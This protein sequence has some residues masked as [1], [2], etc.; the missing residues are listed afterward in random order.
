MSALRALA[1]RGRFLGH[2]LRAAIRP[3]LP[4]TGNYFVA[5]ISGLELPRHP[6]IRRSRPRP[7]EH[8]DTDYARRFDDTSLFY[9]VFQLDG[10]VVAVGPP[11]RNLAEL[12]DSVS[13]SLDGQPVSRESDLL[14]N[15]ERSSFPGSGK[16]LSL[17]AGAG[18]GRLEA[19]VQPAQ[20]DVF[21]GRRVLLT[22]SK[23][24]RLDWIVDWLEFHT[25]V[26]GVDAALIYDNGSQ[27]YS[28]ADLL[29]RIR[30]VPGLAA[31]VVVPWPY[32]YGPDGLPDGR[33]WDSSFAQPVMWE[34]A[35]RRFL[36]RAAAMVNAD[37]DELIVAASGGTLF[38]HLARS[39]SGALLYP[40][41]WITPVRRGLHWSGRRH[42][43]F[44]YR[45]DGEAPYLNKWTCVPARVPDDVQLGI[46]R[47]IGAFEATYVPEITFRHFR[48]ITN[49]WKYDRI[50]GR[51]RYRPQRHIEDEVWVRQMRDI[52][53]SD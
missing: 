52:G 10:R 3:P 9:D 39:P 34:H 48:G 36:M 32:K 44:R 38:D 4:Q 11:L 40:G 50:R 23:D 2:R 5:G 17:E 30:H 41:Q 42:R 14:L 28:P 19:P 25:R 31:A 37:I 16:V 18:V 6:S 29:E 7:L 43:D 35:R 12:V 49:N 15:V 13:A 20:L 1:Y 27:S 24:N 8:Q 33:F 46:H 45:L 21:D 51:R 22:I 53:W 26:H 47:F